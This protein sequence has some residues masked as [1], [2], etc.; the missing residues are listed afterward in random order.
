MLVELIIFVGGL[1]I[2]YEGCKVISYERDRDN[3]EKYKNEFIRDY[4]SKCQITPNTSIDTEEGELV[5]C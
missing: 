2:G 5:F 1:I 3:L 4:Y